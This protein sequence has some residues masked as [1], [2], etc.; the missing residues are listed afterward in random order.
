MAGRRQGAQSLAALMLIAVPLAG[1][2][3]VDT[4]G[5]AAAQAGRF[6]S[7]FDLLRLAGEQRAAEMLRQKGARIDENFANL[8]QL[9]FTLPGQAGEGSELLFAPG[10]PDKIEG[11]TLVPPA[12]LRITG[13]DVEARFGAG[14]RMPALPNQGWRFAHRDGALNILAVYDSNPELPSSRV[15]RLVATPG[16]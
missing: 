14:R 13:A 6:D 10:N 2:D 9:L 16:G 7:L 8:G 11:L 1:C 12:D 5:D 15:I 4:G 3:A